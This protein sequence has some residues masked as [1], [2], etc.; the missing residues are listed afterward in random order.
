M[1][2]EN[3]ILIS[4]HTK[5]LTFI[6]QKNPEQYSQCIWD[7][8]TDEMI[9]YPDEI[10]ECTRKYNIINLNMTAAFKHTSIMIII[11]NSYHFVL[12]IFIFSIP[13]NT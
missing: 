7:K 10:D 6:L 5:P 1:N 12:S 9:W 2:Y 13:T 11:M 8:D 4:L 3:H